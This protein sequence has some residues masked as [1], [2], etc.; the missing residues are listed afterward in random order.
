MSE[1]SPE[2]LLDNFVVGADGDGREVDVPDG[3]V[4]AGDRRDRGVLLPLAVDR[5]YHAAAQDE[6]PDGQP[7]PYHPA[8]NISLKSPLVT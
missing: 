6:A 2:V 8:N 4:G 3:V 7:Q 5:P 1:C